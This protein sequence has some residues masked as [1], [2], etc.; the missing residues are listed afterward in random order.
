MYTKKILIEGIAREFEIL[1]H[2]GSKVTKENASFKFS[3]SQRSIEDLEYYIVSSLPTQVRL[4]VDWT[5]NTDKYKEYTQE[6]IKF[7]WKRFVIELNKSLKI[8]K[9]ELR[10]VKG[11][12]RKE[13]I[14]IFGRKWTRGSFLVDYI[15]TFLGAYKMQLF[16]QLKASGVANI[17][18]SN[19]WG[20]K[21][22]S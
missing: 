15:F 4:V 2:L 18:T 3:E 1:K 17:G 10:T 8:I 21:D 5:R 13:E 14:E 11:K 6:V 20:W 19:L 7:T 9:K 22:M 16:L 12:A